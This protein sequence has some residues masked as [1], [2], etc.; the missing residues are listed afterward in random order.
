LTKKYKW[1][2]VQGKMTNGLEA[3]VVSKFEF[4]D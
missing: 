2:R 4:E 3:W 1:E